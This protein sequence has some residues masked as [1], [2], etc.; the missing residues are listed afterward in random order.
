MNVFLI[1]GGIPVSIYDN[2][3]TFRDISR[4]FNLDGDLLKPIANY[5]FNVGNSDQKDR[6]LIYKFGK[7][8][9][10]DIKQKGLKS[11]RDKSIITLIKPPAIMASGVTT[12]FLPENPDEMYNRLKLLLQEK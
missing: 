8:M 7:D 1:N 4:S 12:I 9:R 6:K 3:L 11:D 5:D 2:M 10:F